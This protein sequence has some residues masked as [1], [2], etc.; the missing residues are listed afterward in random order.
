MTKAPHLRQTAAFSVLFL[1]GANLLIGCSYRAE[2]DSWISALIAMAVLVLW[3]LVLARISALCPG[4]N[5]FDLV[6]QFPGWLRYPFWAILTVYCFSQA[7]LTVRAYAGFAHIV[8][9]KNTDIIVI[10]ALTCL[11]ILFFLN[12]EDRTL[13]QFSYVSAI[14]IVFIIFLLFCLLAP[15]YRTE[16]LFPILYD[17]TK[18]LIVCSVENLTFPFGNAFLLL[19]VISFPGEPK[20]ERN[21]WL[22]VTA[23]AGIL[24]LIVVFQDLLLLGGKLAK[25]I[26]FPYNFSSSLINVGDF[27]S[28]VE[29]FSSLFFFL[30]AIV[31]SAY[32]MKLTSRGIRAMAPAKPKAIAFPLAALLCGYA[33]IVFKNT[34]SLFNYLQIFPYLAIPL[35]F[36]LPLAIWIACEVRAKRAK[37]K[38]QKLMTQQV[39]AL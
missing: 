9:L 31:R 7:A 30:S 1:M 28:R 20:K 4:Q 5:I 8:S 29:V 33:A 23:I 3:S 14:P 35:Q 19:G 15:R 37:R 39:R 17:N 34:D 18:D 38:E 12:R 24:S 27:F 6:R 25:I 21:T 32:F 13:Y 36:G 10:L 26:D 22:S 16:A 11:T 2:Q